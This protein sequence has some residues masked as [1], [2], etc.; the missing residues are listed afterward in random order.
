MF[1][2]K[3]DALT[4]LILR[5]EQVGLQHLYHVSKLLLPTRSRELLGY[6]TWEKRGRGGG[7]SVGAGVVG[8]RAVDDALNPD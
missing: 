7:A 3:A 8:V 5:A 1:M 2:H 4:K 6:V